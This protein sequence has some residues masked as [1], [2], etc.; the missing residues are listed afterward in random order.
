[1]RLFRPA[2]IALEQRRSIDA[3]LDDAFA[4]L[5]ARTTSVGPARV[6]AAVR[7]TPER[8][9]LGALELLARASQLTVAAAFSAFLFAGSVASVTAVPTTPDISREAVRVGTRCSDRSTPAP[10]TTAPS[11]ATSPRTPRWPAVPARRR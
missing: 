5:R 6:R 8:P 9:R 11:P 3:A 4:P 1:V 7:W 2:P 10:P